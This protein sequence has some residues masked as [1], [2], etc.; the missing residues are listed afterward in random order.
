MRKEIIEFIKEFRNVKTENKIEYLENDL[1][2]N[3]SVIEKLK[4]E[5]E[6]DHFMV[7]ALK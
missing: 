3:E 4:S 2:K 7:T 6:Y 1:N 5:I